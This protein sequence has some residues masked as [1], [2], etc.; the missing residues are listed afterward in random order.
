MDGSK[1]PLNTAIF[2]DKR[3]PLSLFARKFVT[4][5]SFVGIYKITYKI[6]LVKYPLTSTEQSTPFTV[7]I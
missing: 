6:Y 2:D 4:N 7:T 1:T 5:Y 3:T